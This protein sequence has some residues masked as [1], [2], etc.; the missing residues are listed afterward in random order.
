MAASTFADS[1]PTRIYDPNRLEPPNIS[2]LGRARPLLL[3]RQDEN[4][5]DRPRI[6]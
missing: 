1:N 2:A 4:R 5:G 6:R 3:T